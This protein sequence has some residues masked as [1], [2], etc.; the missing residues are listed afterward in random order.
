MRNIHL[1]EQFMKENDIEYDVP[2][3]IE[4][5]CI[6]YEVIFIK[7]FSG[8]VLVR[9]DSVLVS[10]SELGGMIYRI[11]FDDDIKI[12]KKLWKPKEDENYYY[13]DCYGN[14]NRGC[15]S[16]HTTADMSRHIIGNC[17]R[18]EIKAEKHKNDVL[19]I[20]NGEPLVK[21]ED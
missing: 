8:D 12:V 11:L 9:I 4:I 19:K 17:F 18:T 2:F 16:S 14:I 15:F 5:G 1:I 6:K 3:K 7:N 10:V 13:I 21:W 20:L